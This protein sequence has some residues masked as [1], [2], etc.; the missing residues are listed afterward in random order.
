MMLIIMCRIMPII[1]MF[2]MVTMVVVIFILTV[3][4]VL[5]I[6][7]R[8]CSWLRPWGSC[9]GKEGCL[10]CC[11]RLAQGLEQFLQFASI[12]PDTPA[13]GAHIQFDT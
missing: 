11:L 3:A 7:G 4:T 13:L 9:W 6:G 8:L 12:Q 2:F 1:P 10:R 5:V